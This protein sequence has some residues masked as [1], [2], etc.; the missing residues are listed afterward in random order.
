[1]VH[2]NGMEWFL[3]SCNVYVHIS[4]VF[5]QLQSTILAVALY[6]FEM[7]HLT[8]KKEYKLQMFENKELKKIFVHMIDEVTEQFRNYIIVWGIQIT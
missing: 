2:D 7:W 4:N 8:V 3:C 5:A 6:E 1:M